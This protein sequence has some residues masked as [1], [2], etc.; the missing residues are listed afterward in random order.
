M[1]N[2]LT[3]EWRKDQTLKRRGGQPLLSIEEFGAEENYF[4]QMPGQMTPETLYDRRWALAL[5]E[6]ALVRLQERWKAEGK[7]REFEAFKR[8]L[9]AEARDG[10]YA[11]LAT[12]LNQSADSI[13]VGVCR[14]RRQYRQMV[15]EEISHTVTSQA[16]I[17]EE[18]RYLLACCGGALPPT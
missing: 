13:A 14:L 3:S 9:S 17:E 1:N 6:R 18:L 15:R 2:F 16:E 11:S 10:E 5:F 4:N 12:S 8:F 7:Q